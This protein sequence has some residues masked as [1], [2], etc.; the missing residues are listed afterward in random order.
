MLA[1]IPVLVVA[2][3]VVGL[4]YAFIEWRWPSIRGQRRLRTGVFTDVTWYFFTATAGQLITGVF[5]FICI[6]AAAR[7]LGVGPTADQLR[8][9]TARET[10]ITHWPAGLQV[11]ALIV[12]VDFLGYWQHRAFHTFARLWRIHAVHH[13]STD[14]DWLSAVRVHPLN[15]ALSTAFIATPLLL[16]G[17]NAGTLGAYVP[18]LTV[19]AIGLHANVWW[20]YGPLRY[21]V[22]SPAFH[23]WHHSKEPEAI[24]KNFA[25]LLPVWDLLFGSFYLPRGVQ[26]T[27]FGVNDAVPATFLRQLLYPLRRARGSVEPAS[28]SA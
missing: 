24:N 22:S 18:V 14:L 9:L 11:I 17:F 27:N 3:L 16:L 26:A 8:G 13:S 10:A 21:V 7:L 28:R 23:R 19:Y 6:V 20:D 5:V 25:G 2:L 1:R 4:A 15:D 12:V